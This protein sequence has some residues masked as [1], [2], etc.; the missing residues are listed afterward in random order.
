[1]VL[2]E[3][4]EAGPH[5]G[6][7]ASKRSF[8]EKKASSMILRELVDITQRSV[9]PDKLHLFEDEENPFLACWLR[10]SVG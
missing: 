5:V 3:N 1:M 8:L 10:S 6:M 4:K 2:W 9:T 7:R